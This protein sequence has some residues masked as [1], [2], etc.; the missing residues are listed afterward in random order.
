MADRGIGPSSSPAYVGGRTAP[1]PTGVAAVAIPSLK[2]QFIL[3][4]KPWQGLIP[5]AQLQ[6]KQTCMEA[7]QEMLLVLCAIWELEN[8]RWRLGLLENKL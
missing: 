7:R 2:N 6:L 1:L 4:P 3:T 5:P 8:S